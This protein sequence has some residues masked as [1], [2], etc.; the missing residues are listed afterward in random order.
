MNTV[1]IYTLSNPITKEIRYIGKT[2]G[3]LNYRLSAHISEAKSGRCRNHKNSWVVSLLKQ[4]LMPTI[5]LLDEIPYTTDWEWLEQYWISQF[6]A[7]GFSIINMT[8]GGDGN[9]NQIFSRE[10]IDKRTANI[11]KK[12]DSGEIDYSIRAKKISKSHMG[13]IVTQITRDKLRDINLG[14]RYSIE[15]KLKKSKGGVQ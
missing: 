13:K 5:E 9:K 6:R 12:I 1:K 4:D 7:W 14:K 8:D 3:K 10:S 15:T 2:V 11:Q